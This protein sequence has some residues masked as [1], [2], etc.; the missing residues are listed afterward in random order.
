VSLSLWQQCLACLQNDLPPTEFS[1]WIRPLK[2]KLNKNMLE[3]SAPNRFVLDWVQDKYLTNLNRLLHNFCGHKPPMLKFKVNN[4]Y[5]GDKIR[6]LIT[7]NYQCKNFISAWNNTS[8]SKQLSYTDNLNKKYKFNNFIQGKSNQLACSVTYQIS[9]NPGNSYNPLFLCGGTGLGKTHLLHAVGNN[10]ISNQ[11]KIKVVYIH[12]EH[13]V[14]NMVRALQNNTIEEFKIYYRSIDVLLMDDIQFFANKERSQ[15]EFFHIFNTLLEGNQQIILTS[16]RYPKEIIGL[17]DRLK[18]RFGWGLTVPIHPPELNTR[19]DILMNKAD[20]NNI[21]LSYEVAVFIAKNL[22][23][24][25]RELEGALNCIIANANFTSRNITVDFVREALQ[26]LFALEEKL[27]TID[28]IQKQVSEYYNITISDLLSRCRSR[29]IVRPRQ[30][31]MAMSKK[32]TY[33]SLSEIGNAF[34]GRDHTTVLHA[35][36][37]IEQLRE[38]NHDI[39]KDYSNLIKLLSS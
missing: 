37:K 14:Q 5:T 35:C 10:I 19:V 26:D 4:K 23:S 15:E 11:F 6:Q 29:S 28:N 17:E 12:S 2:A 13:F 24:N 16:D 18:S 21:N 20:I 34:G 39:K 27:I 33:H 8:I 3:L 7:L 32:L 22:R 1:M 25:I 36:Q 30:I 38:E 31:A 9:K